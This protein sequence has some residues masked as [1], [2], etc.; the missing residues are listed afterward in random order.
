[1]Y[2]HLPD[3]H[4]LMSTILIHKSLSQNQVFQVCQC[5][6][7]SGLFLDDKVAAS[8]ASLLR[9]ISLSVTLR[10][11]VFGLLARLFLSAGL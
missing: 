1:M 5:L 10:Q 9:F 4:F 7:L 8:S 6:A 3:K 2:N 11:L